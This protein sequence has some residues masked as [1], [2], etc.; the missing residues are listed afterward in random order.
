MG[1]PE[2][3]SR[4]RLVICIFIFE[5]TL[6]S[7]PLFQLTVPR[8][9]GLTFIMVTSFNNKTSGRPSTM[10]HLRPVE[11]MAFLSVAPYFFINQKW[12]SHA[13]WTTLAALMNFSTCTQKWLETADAGGLEF[14]LGKLKEGD[15]I[16][17]LCAIHAPHDEDFVPLCL[18]TLRQPKFRLLTAGLGGSGNELFCEMWVNLIFL[19]KFRLVNFEARDTFTQKAEIVPQE[20][21]RITQDAVDLSFRLDFPP[22]SLEQAASSGSVPEVEVVSPEKSKRSCSEVEGEADKNGSPAKRI[23]KDSSCLQTPVFSCPPLDTE[24]DVLDFTEDED[25]DFVTACEALF[26]DTI[27]EDLP[28]EGKVLDEPS[29][30]S[31]PKSFA[32]E[33]TPSPDIGPPKLSVE[34]PPF[35]DKQSEHVQEAPILG[36]KS[37]PEPLSKVQNDRAEILPD[38][39]KTPQNFDDHSV[40]TSPVSTLGSPS[41]YRFGQTPPREDPPELK[42]PHFDFHVDSQQKKVT[43]V[44]DSLSFSF[45]FK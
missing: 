24:T 2:F 18:E 35:S 19:L 12:G 22:A 15:I 14:V 32:C 17:L 40:A 23:R 11:V 5:P 31:P 41:V 6:K 33:A 26:N 38:A 9:G 45:H 16:N 43:V 20:V 3:E 30:I 13:F 37:T 27:F 39:P 25:F 1:G 8:T 21:P 7:F 10:V 4:D 36:E 42:K 29:Q 34:P 44:T 28:K